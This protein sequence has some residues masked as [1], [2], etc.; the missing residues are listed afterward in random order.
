MFWMINGSF[1]DVMICLNIDTLHK[2]I[3]LVNCRVYHCHVYYLHGRWLNAL[4]IFGCQIRHQ[5]I[6]Q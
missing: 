3:V 1:Q 6:G 4:G 2:Y 5:L